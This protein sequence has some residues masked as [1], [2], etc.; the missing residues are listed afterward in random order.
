[1]EHAAL[2]KAVTEGRI[3]DADAYQIAFDN[4]HSDSKLRSAAYSI[5]VNEHPYLKRTKDLGEYSKIIRWGD[6]SGPVATITVYTLCGVCKEHVVE[7]NFCSA[8][9]VKLPA[10]PKEQK[11]QVERPKCGKCGGDHATGNH[12]RFERRTK[13]RVAAL[14]KTS[15]DPQPVMGEEQKKLSKEKKYQKVK[16]N[17]SGKSPKGP[18]SGAVKTV[19]RPVNQK[20]TDPKTGRKNQSGKMEMP[21]SAGLA[22]RT[23][24]KIRVIAL[25]PMPS[26]AWNFLLREGPT[27]PSLAAQLPNLAPLYLPLASSYLT[28]KQVARLTQVYG[29]RPKWLKTLPDGNGRVEVRRQS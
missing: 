5:Y 20:G 13:K 2:W 28:T 3:K 10:K 24:G 23:D 14:S 25:Y 27:L 15:L 18:E 17:D 22:N 16:T 8:C 4:R 9:G 26:E 19:P 21:S 7:R 6:E 11:Q 1:L 29:T 12:S